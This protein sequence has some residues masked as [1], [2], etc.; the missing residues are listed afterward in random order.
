MIYNDVQCIILIYVHICIYIYTV[1]LE[2][3]Q[4]STLGKVWQHLSTKPEKLIA[5]IA[6]NTWEMY[7]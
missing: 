1:L 2:C 5:S 6:S 3:V 4:I 7:P